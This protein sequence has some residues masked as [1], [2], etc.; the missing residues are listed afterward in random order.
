MINIYE[1]ILYIAL[2]TGVIFTFLIIFYAVKHYFKLKEDT[3]ALEISKSAQSKAYQLEKKIKKLEQE[4]QELPKTGSIPNLTN[5]DN[6]TLEQAAE[7]IGMDPKE[8]NNPLVRPL[9]EKFFENIKSRM[10]QKNTSGIDEE[11]GY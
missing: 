6:L 7:M 8:L 4:E 10:K 3:K 5:I 1:L 9:A 2:F 11:D